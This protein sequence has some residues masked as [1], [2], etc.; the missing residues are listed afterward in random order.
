MYF[1]IICFSNYTTVQEQPGL[2]EGLGKGGREG[3]G[4]PY[5]A[6]RYVCIH[7]KSFGTIW[8]VLYSIHFLLLTTRKHNGGY[9]LSQA[10][11]QLTMDMCRWDGI[12]NSLF[13]TATHLSMSQ[14]EPEHSAY[15]SAYSPTFSV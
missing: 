14:S 2:L 12:V 1:N 13:I 9:S 3:G 8:H 5:I 7:T 6:R 11:Y 15:F 4:V 10:P